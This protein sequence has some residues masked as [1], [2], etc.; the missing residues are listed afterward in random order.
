MAALHETA[1]PV[2]A[3]SMRNVVALNS[4]T[5][6]T[7]LDVAEGGENAHPHANP[8]GILEQLVVQAEGKG[9]GDCIEPHAAGPAGDACEDAKSACYV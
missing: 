3:K 4:V 9:V 2:A 5:A 6:S 7:R 8:V 1:E